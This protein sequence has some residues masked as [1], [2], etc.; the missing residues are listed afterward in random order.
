MHWFVIRVF[1][2]DSFETYLQASLVS[3]EK[4]YKK[5][6]LEAQFTMLRYAPLGIGLGAIDRLNERRVSDLYEEKG[7]LQIDDDIQIALAAQKQYDD[8]YGK[9]DWDAWESLCIANISIADNKTLV[10]DAQNHLNRMFDAYPDEYA[11]K[12]LVVSDV[13]VSKKKYSHVE[14]RDCTQVISMIGGHDRFK[15]WMTHIHSEYLKEIFQILYQELYNSNSAI[16]RIP[17]VPNDRCSDYAFIVDR[18]K[19][20]PSATMEEL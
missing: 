15:E 11:R 18:I 8:L 14:I 4:E 20:V 19:S 2:R 13:S 17:Y 10:G 5:I 12:L 16:L 3:S 6:L 1:L 9:G 7:F